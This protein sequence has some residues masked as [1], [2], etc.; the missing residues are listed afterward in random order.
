[1]F[2]MKSIAKHNLQVKTPSIKTIDYISDVHIDTREND[3]V[4][5]L[6]DVNSPICIV[7]GDIGLVTHHNY[8][9]FMRNLSESYEDAYIILG[10][11]DYNLGCLYENKA[12]RYWTPLIHTKVAQYRNI[13][14][15][16]KAIVNHPAGFNIVGCTLWSK[17]LGRRLNDKQLEHNAVHNEH[18]NFIDASLEYLQ[19][20]TI[21]ATHFVPSFGLIEKKYKERYSHTSISYFASDLEEV[22]E[23][24]SA[25]VCGHTHSR[26]V[27]KI[28]STYC[29]VNAIGH[30][31]MNTMKV[32]TWNISE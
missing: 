5:S 27:T 22:I 3:D 15:L 25:W 28:G 8:D 9:I 1:M 24:S 12:V 20:P 17:I 30:G 4:P 11:H 21:V 32:F 29:G 7:A 2:S 14:L 26:F 19:G 18:A 10:N 6:S 16:D 31:N 23:K 13:H